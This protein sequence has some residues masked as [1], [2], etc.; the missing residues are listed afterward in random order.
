MNWYGVGFYLSI[1]SIKFRIDNMLRNDAM[2]QL[3]PCNYAVYW[4]LPNAR[5]MGENKDTQE[6]SHS[7]VF[8]TEIFFCVFHNSVSILH[9][10]SHCWH[11]NVGRIEICFEM[12]AFKTHYWNDW[13][14]EIWPS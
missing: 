4:I 12:I 6:F 8:I 1:R 7:F 13:K 5:H 14:P 3:F 2:C 10:Y 11:Y 9:S